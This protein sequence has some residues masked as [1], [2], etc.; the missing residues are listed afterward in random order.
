MMKQQQNQRNERET[1]RQKENKIVK[2][3]LARA[4]R[5]QIC[6]IFVRL[7]VLNK[8]ISSAARR[9]KEELIQAKIDAAQ[10]LPMQRTQYEVTRRVKPA[11]CFPFSLLLIE[12]KPCSPVF[13]PVLILLFSFLRFAQMQK[14][15]QELPQRKRCKCDQSGH[16]LCLLFL[17]FLLPNCCWMKLLQSQVTRK[18]KA[19]KR[20]SHEQYVCEFQNEEHRQRD[21]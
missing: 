4:D 11:F 2:A 19:D 18:R 17:P 16:R 10:Q 1:S 15:L 20:W 12:L 9:A 21:D 8:Q 13:I 3:R 5:R 7:A 6:A 14:N